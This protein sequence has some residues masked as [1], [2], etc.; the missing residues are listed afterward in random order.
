[1]E[2]V[3]DEKDREVGERESAGGVCFTEQVEF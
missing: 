2:G 1:M 3:P